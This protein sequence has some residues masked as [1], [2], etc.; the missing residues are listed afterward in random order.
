MTKDSQMTVTPNRTDAEHDVREGARKRASS[1]S[2][3]PGFG[4]EHS[5]EALPGALP[6]GKNSPQNP[7]FGLYAELLSGTGFVELRHNTRRTWM[8]RIRPSVTHPPF[9][10]IDNGTLHT[11]PFT[12]IPTEPNLLFWHPRP[13]PAPGT[14]F[15]SG[16]W[17]LGGNGSPGERNG[18]AL[19]LYTADTSMTDRVFSNADGELLIVPE[20]GGLL[21]HTELGLLSVEPGF[22]A[23]IPRAMKFR[24]EILEPT[25]ED[26]ELGFV[27]GYVLENFGSAFSLP[28][29]GFVGQSGMANARDFQAPVAAYDDSESDVEVI[30]KLDGNLWSSTYDHSPLDVVAWHG[31]SVPF[32]YNLYHFQVLGALNFDHPDPSL[33]TALTS[34]TAISGANNIDIAFAG[35]RWLVTEDTFRPAYYHRNVSSEYAGVIKS[36]PAF[37]PAFEPGIGGLTNM[38]TPHGSGNDIWEFGSNA[39]LAPQKLDGLMFLL[40][41]NLPIRL[42]SQAGQA[43]GHIDDETMSGR[44]TLQSNFGK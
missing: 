23:L 32:V 3:L 20:R 34:T 40:E 11:P 43:V 7:A 37:G 38:L 35:P 33:L 28:E 41:T 36:T 29:L 5:S 25:T 16:L 31:N 39:E 9:S 26:E 15:V 8:Y 44:S 13:A 19:H 2:Y 27:R 24:V 4:N 6:V 17:T 22:I 12:D 14:D 42:T 30:H 21:I 10:R 1:L 18:M